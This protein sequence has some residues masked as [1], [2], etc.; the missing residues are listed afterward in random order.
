MTEL[1]AFAVGVGIVGIIDLLTD[2]YVCY[3]ALRMPDGARRILG[4]DGVIISFD[5]IRYDL[6]ELA[7]IVGL[8]DTDALLLKGTHCDMHIHACNDRCPPREGKDGSILG[9]DL[10]AAHYP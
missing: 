10:R 8:A 6:P 1:L 2:A 7:K 4:C 9:P 3:R 5:G